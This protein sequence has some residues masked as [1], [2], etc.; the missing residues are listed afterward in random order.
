[1]T[2]MTIVYSTVWTIQRQQ[3]TALDCFISLL[4]LGDNHCMLLYCIAALEWTNEIGY[5][6]F[7]V[8][9]CVGN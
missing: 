4:Y 5:V 3:L 8:S 2:E 7:Q 6:L 9:L 1:M